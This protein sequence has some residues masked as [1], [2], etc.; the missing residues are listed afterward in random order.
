MIADRLVVGSDKAIYIRLFGYKYFV[1]DT[2]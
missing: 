1:K 2:Y